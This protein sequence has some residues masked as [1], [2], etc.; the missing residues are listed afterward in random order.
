MALIGPTV[1][2]IAPQPFFTPR[3]TPFSVYYRTRTMA[4][5]G[6]Q[7]D[8]LTYGEGADVDIPAVRQVRIPRVP[9]L[10]P[11]PVGP[12]W[13][14][15]VLDVVMVLWTVGLLVRH[16]YAVV[17]AHEEAVFWCRF[18]QPVFRFRLIYD[19]HSSLPQQLSNFR[20]TESKLITRAFTWL[21]D[22][23]LRRADA[24]ITICPDLRDYAL[25][26]GVPPEKHLLIENSLFDDVELKSTPGT[27]VS[28]TGGGLAPPA[29]DFARPTVVYAGTF[30][31]YQGIDLLLKAFA[32]VCKQVPA[33]Q[34]VMAGGTPEQISAARKV[35]Q[36]A[37]L[38]SNC[39]FAGRV[40]KGE[41]MRLTRSATVL[42]SP[43]LHGTNTPLKIYEQ[44]ASGKAIVA[45][46][47][48]SHTQVLTDEVCVLVEPQ[49]EDL[50]RGLA[51]ALH[52]D[53]LRASLGRGAMALYER[54][55]SRPIYEQ[56]IV[57]LLELV[58]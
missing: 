29:I 5:K 9:F 46:K 57:R 25:Q 58:S 35:A 20:F 6:A 44:L 28:T 4:Q 52:D 53:E 7:I 48:W 45:T 34:L 36:D 1:L 11:I 40:T 13:K 31:P 24:V 8:L 55:Y 47:I 38:Q 10:G 21:E 39:I 3:G 56:K 18:L 42:V 43:R 15:A 33:A 26:A 41:A 27:R 51:L 30:E 2:V 23:A 37:G 32:L 54:E 14:K 16:R 12:S 19:M 22:G 49:P 50:A 17:H